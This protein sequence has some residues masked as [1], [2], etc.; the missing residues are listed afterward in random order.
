MAQGRPRDEGKERQWRRW[1]GEWRASGLG[2]RA[3]CA[4]RGLAE[5]RFYAWRRLLEKRAAKHATF[6]PVQV[7]ADQVAA[8]SNALEVVLADGRAI[9]VAPGFDPATLRALLTVLEECRPC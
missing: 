1:V 5:P 7:V 4:R 6:L 8:A 9:R 3:F 2:V